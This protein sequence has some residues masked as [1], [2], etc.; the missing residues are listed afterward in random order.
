[1]SWLFLS[2]ILFDFELSSILGLTNP[3]H[4]V[5]S[6]CIVYFMYHVLKFYIFIL[7]FVVHKI[8]FEMVKSRTVVLSERED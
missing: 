2:S 5:I 4:T 1:M 7:K 6:K 8:N 3:V